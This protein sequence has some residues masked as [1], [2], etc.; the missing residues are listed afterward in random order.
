MK[1]K[2]YKIAL[3]GVTASLSIL[4]LFLTG[5][6][7]FLTYICPALSGAV[8]MIMV[9]EISKKWAFATFVV[10]SILSVFTTP[11]KEAA[12]MFIFLLGYYPILKSVIEKMN[13][14]VPEVIVK[15]LVFNVSV[16]LAY[17]LIINVFGMAQILEDLGA[18]G[19]YGSV[20][21]LLAANLVFLLY[22]KCLTAYATF[23]I[24]RIRPLF[25]K[26]SK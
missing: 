22:D 25:I 5:F 23:Y 21:F 13:H 7:P 12:V 24:K 9:I 10:V 4:M 19:Q 3:G 8:L 14:K 2:S 1:N 20:I 17:L 26:H 16:I 15:L 18:I 11:D 6:G